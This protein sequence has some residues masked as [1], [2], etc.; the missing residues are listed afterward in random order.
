MQIRSWSICDT[1]SIL[2]IF[3]KLINNNIKSAL[4]T[5]LTGDLIGGIMQ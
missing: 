2:A 4:L 3:A 1:P 5:Y